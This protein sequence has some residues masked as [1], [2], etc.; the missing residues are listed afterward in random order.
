MNQDV[1]LIYLGF[2]GGGARL[3]RDISFDLENAGIFP[4]IVYRRECEFAEYFKQTHGICVPIDLPKNKLRMLLFCNHYSKMIFKRISQELVSSQN[5]I[6]VMPHPLNYN[7]LKKL[8]RGHRN[9]S[10]TSI[11]HDDRAHSGEIWPTKGTIK[12]LIKQSSKIVFLSY[13]VCVKFKMQKKFF[14]SELEALPLLNSTESASQENTLIVPGRIKKYKNILGIFDFARQ[15]ESKYT[16]RIVGSGKLPKENPPKNVFIENTWMS[17]IDFDKLI[18][19]SSAL[20]SLYSEATQSGP[21]AIAKAYGV[22]IIANGLGGTI[23]QL[24]NYPRKLILKNVNVNVEA[25]TRLI[26]TPRIDEKNHKYW[27]KMRIS[28]HFISDEYSN[29]E[30]R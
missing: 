26:N 3:T 28:Q 21:I 8:S 2:R 27:P 25:V 9:I 19:N 14:V 7:L 1:T 30:V 22:P 6:F 15:L 17:T 5:F 18:C 29:L 24:E 23:E 4:N 13:S 10:T 12:R 20:V 11:I 16:I